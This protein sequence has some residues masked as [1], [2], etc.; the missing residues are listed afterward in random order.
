MKKRTFYTELAYL[1]GLLLIA[2]G[3]AL[4][5]RGSFGVSMIVA[6]AYL[7]YRYVSTFLP[8]FT[9][10]TAEYCFQAVLLLLMSLA[11]RRFRL[12]FLFSFVT[13]VIYGFILDGCMLLAALLPNGSLV[14]R[15][16]W[17]LLGMP[18][19]ALGVSLMFRTY[20]PAEVYEV[21]VKDVSRHYGVDITAFKT[22]Y[23]RASCLLALIMSFSFFGMWHFVG[24]NWG[25]ILCAVINGPSVGW[26]GRLLDR[27]FCFRDALP[28]RAFF[29][30]PSSEAR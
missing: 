19:G 30:E 21:F 6:P 29:S 13:A 20:L 14:W 1:S 16:V 27:S 3:A 8:W 22:W 28:W 7:L 4:M 18:M 17:F 11:L 9:F 15:F 2:L 5:E 12:R 25:T 23:D 10:G 24:V 26:F